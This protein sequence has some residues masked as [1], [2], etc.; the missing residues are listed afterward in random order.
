MEDITKTSLVAE[1]K[2]SHARLKVASDDFERLIEL[3]T[4]EG[5]RHRF[6]LGTSPRTGSGHVRAVGQDRVYLAP[7]LSVA[8][9]PVHAG[10]W[11]DSAYVKVN[12]DQVTSFTLDNSQG[13]FYLEKDDEQGWVVAGGEDDRGWTRKR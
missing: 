2:A 13:M 7:A 8:V 11:V 5:D 9:A 6:Y 10:F 4:A 12:A 3:D 1:T